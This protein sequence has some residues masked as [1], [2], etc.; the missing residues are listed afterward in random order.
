MPALP[1][2]R[3]PRC[4]TCWRPASHEVGFTKIV[5]RR[6]GSQYNDLVPMS[7]ACP[8]CAIRWPRRCRRIISR[9]RNAEVWARRALIDRILEEEGLAPP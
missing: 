8:D 9:E 7:L 5:I 1:R 2:D 4:R 3:G 6:D